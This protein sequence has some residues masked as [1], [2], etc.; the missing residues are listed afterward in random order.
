MKLHRL[1]ASLILMLCLTPGLA[2]AASQQ[3]QP[4]QQPPSVPSATQEQPGQTTETQPQAEQQTQEA[5]PAPACSDCHELA[6]TFVHN[7]HARGQVT[8]GTVDNGVCET[9]HA[10]ASEHALTGDPAQ[11]AVPRGRKGTDETCLMCHDTANER[12][13]HRTGMHANS[14]HVNCLSCHSIHHSAPRAT[15]LLRLPDP[16]VCS[17][18]HS[19]QVAEFRNKPYTHRVGTGTMGCTS[20]H[21]P[22]GRPGRASLRLTRTGERPCLECHTDKRGPYVFPHGANQF[23]E[24]HGVNTSGECQSC[25]APHGSSNP[26]MLKRGSVAQLCLE[27]HSPIGP[28]TLGSQPP[29]FHNL[30]DPRYQRCTA[31]HV[32]IHGS[33]RSPAL[34]KR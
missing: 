31:C 17:S 23:T 12:K 25:H 32:A 8:N 15:H 27:C 28:D 20:C 21:E 5:T 1:G 13:S 24:S 29:S 19:T 4:Q 33:N 16:Q 30:I 11:V 26:S 2:M 22:H 6:L 18:C 7:P 10:G 34:M 9:C 14:E 3:T